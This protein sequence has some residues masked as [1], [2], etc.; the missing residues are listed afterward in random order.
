MER[1]A[2]G[3]IRIC[4]RPAMKAGVRLLRP[5]F[6]ARMSFEVL[7]PA[8][9]ETIGLAAPHFVRAKMG[10]KTWGIPGLAR[11][12]GHIRMWAGHGAWG[13]GVRASRCRVRV[14]GAAVHPAA[15]LWS[16]WSWS[17]ARESAASGRVHP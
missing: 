14:N 17:E 13:M 4:E 9:A 7:A 2:G 11:V 5:A 16:S 3:F 15:A 10:Q 6:T 1:V 12:G 8:P